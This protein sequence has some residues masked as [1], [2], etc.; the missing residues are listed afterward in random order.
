MSDWQDIDSNLRRLA[1]A[2]AA[3]DVEEA[4][5]LRAAEAERVYLY[6]GCSSVVEYLERVLGY[7][8]KVA[9]PLCQRS[10]RFSTN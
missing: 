9:V 8:P 2:R 4:R 7:T 1:K 3:L 5:W 10:C 6:F